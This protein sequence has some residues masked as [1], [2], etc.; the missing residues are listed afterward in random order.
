MAIAVEKPHGVLT[1]LPF[2]SLRAVAEIVPISLLKN[3][4]T[5][6]YSH[7]GPTHQNLRLKALFSEKV[8]FWLSPSEASQM[9][10]TGWSLNVSL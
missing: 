7:V 1:E 6:S 8:E 4:A 3:P 9:S 5:V 10:R 2:R